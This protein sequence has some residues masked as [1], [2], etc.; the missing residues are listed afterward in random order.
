MRAAAAARVA[1]VA[2]QRLRPAGLLL[3]AVL[4][5]V[6]LLP[7][8]LLWLRLL[9]LRPRLGL[10]PLHARAVGRLAFAG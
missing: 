7:A 9:R 1:A 6:G 8:G 5:P 10:H 2:Q 4:R 3:L